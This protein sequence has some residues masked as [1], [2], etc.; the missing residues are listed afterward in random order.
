MLHSI[1]RI[2]HWVAYRR[3]PDGRLVVA[4]AWCGTVARFQGFTVDRRTGSV[5]LPSGWDRMEGIPLCPLCVSLYC[6]DRP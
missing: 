2:R 3:R 5:V 4:C 6:T 1:G